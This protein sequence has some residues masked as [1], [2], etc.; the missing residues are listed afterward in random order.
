[1]KKYNFVV[2]Q[3]T[4]ILKFL[5]QNISGYKYSA[6]EKALRQKDIIINGTRVKQNV[7]IVCGDRVEI[8]LDEKQKDTFFKTVYQDENIIVFN[9]KK[10]YRSLRWGL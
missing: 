3:N 2:N 6:F 8:Y 10:G 4:K 1:M 5:S 7:S 9:K